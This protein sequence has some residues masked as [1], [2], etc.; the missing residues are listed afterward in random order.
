MAFPETLIKV[1][2][3]P[4]SVTID[5]KW[6]G[7]RF[8][9]LKRAIIKKGSI[10][11]EEGNELLA[12]IKSQDVKKIKQGSYHALCGK[13]FLTDNYQPVKAREH[14]K[15]AIR[16]NPL[17]LDNYALFIASWLPEKMIRWLHQKKP[18]RL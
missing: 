6:R 9:K 15:E 1:R 5:E 10:T 7:D 3:N 11:A 8:R 13:K 18:N 14:I 2:F 16:L 12:I 4:N 17:R